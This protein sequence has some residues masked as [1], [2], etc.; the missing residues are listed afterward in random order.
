MNGERTGYID[1]QRAEWVYV[2]LT[3]GHVIC[4]MGIWLV[5]G[6]KVR[7][8]NR[9]RNEEMGRWMDDG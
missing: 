9:W 3:D 5:I 1:R 6:G 8:M 4:W 7:Y 2:G